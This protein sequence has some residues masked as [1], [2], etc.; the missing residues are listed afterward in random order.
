[1]FDLVVKTVERI[2]FSGV[3]GTVLIIPLII[4][5]YVAVGQAR[6]F[7]SMAREIFKGE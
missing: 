6:E 4:L 1:M 3:N 2:V 5:I 7:T